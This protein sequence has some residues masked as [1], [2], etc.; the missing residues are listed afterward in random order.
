MGWFPESE[1]SRLGWGWSKWPTWSWQ[2]GAAVW[3]PRALSICIYEQPC[4]IA[5]LLWR[6]IYATLSTNRRS[7]GKVG[8]AL[9]LLLLCPHIIG[10]K[11]LVA[12]CNSCWN[13]QCFVQPRKKLRRDT[14]SEVNWRSFSQCGLPLWCRCVGQKQYLNSEND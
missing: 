12:R 1:R 8:Q 5:C 9:L 11:F 7:W 10:T 6:G 3:G 13:M 14:R 4:V 2:T